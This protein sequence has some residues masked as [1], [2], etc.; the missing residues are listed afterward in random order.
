F[1]AFVQKSRNLGV[2]VRVD[3]NA[4]KNSIE[5]SAIRYADF[6]ITLFCAE[7]AENRMRERDDFSIGFNSWGANNIGVELPKL[8][9]TAFANL[10]IAEKVG[11]RIEACGHRDVAVT[12]SDH[13]C[14]R[15]RH[16]RTQCNFAITSIEKRVGLFVYYFFGSLRAV[17]VCWLQDTRG[18]FFV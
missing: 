5:D 14:E 2:F 7:G 17:E 3:F 12:C 13:A 9:L 11:Y 15:R 8:A 18:I 16:F 6:K 4:C 1:C 10:L